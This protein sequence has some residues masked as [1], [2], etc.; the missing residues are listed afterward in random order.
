MT[1]AALPR[2]ACSKGLITVRVWRPA[3]AFLAGVQKS[4]APAGRGLFVGA[5][6]VFD[7]L[8]S[9]HTLPHVDAF[10]RMQQRQL[11]GRAGRGELPELYA[12]GSRLGGLRVAFDRGVDR[13]AVNHL[14]ANF[15]AGFE[16][17]DQRIRIV[18]RLRDRGP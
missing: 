11:A 3:S 7:F 4:A 17:V 6:V 5:A 8:S 18:R 15:V 16:F 9:L 14:A 12:A 1:K 10:N 13:G 2:S